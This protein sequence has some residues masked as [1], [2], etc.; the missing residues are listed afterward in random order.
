MLT[1]LLLFVEVEIEGVVEVGEPLSWLGDRHAELI[2]A[3]RIGGDLGTLSGP[4]FT[5]V[6]ALLGIPGFLVGRI[7]ACHGG[8]MS[9]PFPLSRSAI[10]RGSRSKT[11]VRTIQG[12]DGS[13]APV[14]PR[15]SC[16]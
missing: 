8:S 10:R 9:Y 6:T 3:V 4:G 1:S 15:P 2:D 13:Q 12:Q 16:L 5:D 14:G 7:V 11:I